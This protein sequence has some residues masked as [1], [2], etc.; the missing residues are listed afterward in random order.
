LKVII[1][2]QNLKSF[3]NYF[4]NLIWQKIIGLTR[5]WSGKP[6]QVNHFRS[7]YPAYIADEEA[8]K[9]NAVVG[10]EILL[11]KP[12]DTILKKMQF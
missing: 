12:Q 3:Q 1:L 11:K 2:K 10:S 6:H 7:R 5:N 4:Q 9:N 8:R